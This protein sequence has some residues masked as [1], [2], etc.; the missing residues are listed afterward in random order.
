MH[1]IVVVHDLYMIKKKKK[2]FNISNLATFVYLLSLLLKFNQLSKI[3]DPIIFDLYCF[4]I[5]N[6][7]ECDK[8]ERGN[9]TNIDLPLL[10]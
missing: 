8:N 4:L 2:L 5:K 3:A 9:K 1:I 10:V 7:L 6:Y